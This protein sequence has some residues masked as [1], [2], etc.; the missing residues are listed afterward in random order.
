M[1]YGKIVADQIQ[2]SS[3][4][5]VD[6]QYV[7]NGSAKAWAGVIVTSG[8]VL[9][10]SLNISSLTDVSTGNKDYALTNN[11]SYDM[12]ESGFGGMAGG[13]S[14]FIRM[15]SNTMT[16]SNAR[17]VAH[18]STGGSATDMQHNWMWV[19]DLA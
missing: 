3:E 8:D 16:T 17:I 7:V 14:R 15:A 1:A 2:H 12:D 10:Q 13:G 4:G 6:T 11:A 5:T 19:G 18:E 9:A